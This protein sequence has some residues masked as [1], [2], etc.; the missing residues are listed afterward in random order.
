MRKVVGRQSFDE[1]GA[2]SARGAM[3]YVTPKQEIRIGALA[4]LGDT[5][6][7]MRRGVR[8]AAPFVR[9]RM[10]K[11]AD[12]EPQR[13]VLTKPSPMGWRLEDYPGLCRGGSRSLTVPAGRFCGRPSVAKPT[14]TPTRSRTW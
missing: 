4:P 14:V 5:A 10:K 11:E 6:A 9:A 13:G 2:G 1:C 7:A 12:R 8:G 3:N